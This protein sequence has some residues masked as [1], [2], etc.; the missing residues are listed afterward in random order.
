[1]VVLFCIEQNPDHTADQYI[2]DEKMYD[3]V[4]HINPSP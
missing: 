4:S 2:A 3:K 1:M